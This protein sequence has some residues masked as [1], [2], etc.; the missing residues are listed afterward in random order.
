MKLEDGARLRFGDVQVIFMLP[1][2]FFEWVR[3]KMR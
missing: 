3:A 2:A 1:T